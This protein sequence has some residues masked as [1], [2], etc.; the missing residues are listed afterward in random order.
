VCGAAGAF[1]RCQNGGSR[2]PQWT[3]LSIDQSM[4][5]WL[6]PMRLSFCPARRFD[7]SLGLATMSS[8]A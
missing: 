6:K 5:Q 4:P 7:G 8:S 1:R 3:P 2:S